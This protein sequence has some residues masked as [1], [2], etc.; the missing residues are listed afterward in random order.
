MGVGGEGDGEVRR[1]GGQG[2]EEILFFSFGAGAIKL[3]T[4]VIVT[5]L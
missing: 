3:F 4:G 5:V 2:F 1:L